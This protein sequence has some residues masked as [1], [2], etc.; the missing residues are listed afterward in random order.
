MNQ[1]TVISR[2]RSIVIVTVKHNP[3]FMVQSRVVRIRTLFLVLLSFLGLVQVIYLSVIIVVFFLN[4]KTKW[5]VFLNGPTH[6]S[7]NYFRP[8]LFLKPTPLLPG[9]SKLNMKLLLNTKRIPWDNF[10]L[11]YLKYF[12]LVWGQ[13]FWHAYWP[14]QNGLHIR[15]SRSWSW[16]YLVL[17]SMA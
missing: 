4:A 2:L 10:L 15:H 17:K 6:P 7:R 5:N 13:R 8:L 1:E 14:W 11:I 3:M 9:F 16:F 12:L